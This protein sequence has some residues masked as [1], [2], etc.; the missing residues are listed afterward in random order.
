[1]GLIY[2]HTI[3]NTGKSYIGLTT[4][5]MQD[6]LKGHISSAKSGS[7]LEFHE[8]IKLYGVESIDSEIIEDNIECTDLLMEREIHYIDKYNTFYDGYNMTLGVD[9]RTLV[10]NLL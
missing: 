2:K 1:M 9:A 4:G 10:I 5:T 6:R 3:K 8:A 7:T